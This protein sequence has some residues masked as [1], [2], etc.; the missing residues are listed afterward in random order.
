MKPSTRVHAEVNNVSNFL[1]AGVSVSET[2]KW[3]VAIWN[4]LVALLILLHCVLPHKQMVYHTQ[5]KITGVYADRQESQHNN[6]YV[7]VNADFTAS[8]LE[9]SQQTDKC[10]PIKVNMWE[11]TKKHSQSFCLKGKKT[12][13]YLLNQTFDLVMGIHGSLTSELWSCS[14]SYL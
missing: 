1:N 4:A 13:S 10:G 6:T 11:Y 8:Q 7:G 3:F 12:T 5:W 14:Q 2:I 9:S